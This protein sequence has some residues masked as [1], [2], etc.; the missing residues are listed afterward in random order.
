M[1]KNPELLVK[2]WLDQSKEDLKSAEALL[3]AHRYSWCA[4]ICQ[5]SLEKCLKAGYVKDKKAIPP[6]IHKLERLCQLLELSPDKD[7]L[8]DIIE[9]DKYYIAT[10]YPTYIKSLNLK[11]REK[12]QKVFEKTRRIYQ[13]LLENLALIKR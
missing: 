10:R 4:F 7:I 11:T 13:W 6:Y 9:I 12:A 5:Q 3:E 2:H 8:S 1:V